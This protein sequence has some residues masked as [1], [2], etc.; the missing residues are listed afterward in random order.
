MG[1]KSD[2]IS[3][4]ILSVFLALSL[5]A[6][7]ARAAGEPEITNSFAAKELVP[8]DTWKI[9]IKAFSPDARMQY[10]FA[11]VDQ[12]GGMPYPVS[13]SNTKTEPRART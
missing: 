6:G 5:F 11:T 7:G 3:V 1:R 13:M 10:F 9:Y 12:A 4:F 2:F 8:R